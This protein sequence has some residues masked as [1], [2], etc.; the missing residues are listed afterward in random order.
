MEVKVAGY[1]ID[2]E[3]IEE[4]KRQLTQIRNKLGPSDMQPEDH[5]ELVKTIWSE[6]ALFLEK[7]EFT[8]ETISASYARISRYPQSI[9]ELR[10][11]AREEVKKARRSNK[12]IIFDMGH[13]S[14]AEHAV[15]NFDILGLSRFAVEELE[16]GRLDSY[17]EKSQRYITLD[18]DF[19]TPKEFKGSDLEL[20][21]ET[22]EK[23]NK[24]YFKAYP[25]A[26]T[27]FMEQNKEQFGNAFDPIMEVLNTTWTPDPLTNSKLIR[28]SLK[29]IS[30]LEKKPSEYKKIIDR[31][32]GFAKEDARY[33]LSMGIEAQIGC[34]IN[35]RNLEYRIRQ[36]KH[37]KLAEHR[38]LGQKLFE[39]TKEIAPSLI[40]LTDPEEF[41]EATGRELKEDWLKQGKENIKKATQELIEKYGLPGHEQG[42]KLKDPKDCVRFIERT[43]RPDDLIIDALI[44]INSNVSCSD[45]HEL[46]YRQATYDD[47]VEYIKKCLQNLSE[48]DRLPREF[49][50]STMTFEAIM[51]SSCFAQMKRHRMMTL[52]PQDYDPSLGYT[53]PESIK[54]IRMEQEFID[55]FAETSKAFYKLK[56]NNPD[57]ANYVLTNAHRRR[58]RITS[59]VRE[60]YHIARLREDAHAQWDIQNISKEIIKLAKTKA[61]ITM[62]L[63]CGKDKFYDLKKEVYGNESKQS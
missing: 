58:V 4:V 2:A 25:K 46:A 6:A 15:F 1:N 24:M 22:V 23:Q 55:L 56:E 62:M 33:A 8:P 41:K 26:R 27:Y 34:T 18:G 51:S 7:T 38:E 5:D 48:F 17:T 20:Y 44:Q 36:L 13:F 60:L 52:L 42:R 45:A 21:L 19:V 37:S 54:A 57:A 28:K 32:D 53:I 3:I 35:A 50:E 59:N 47:K 40:L 43:T 9:P 30:G 61:P 10:K 63:A 29:Q 49:E 12:A 11:I 39:L 16:K 31:I 14:V